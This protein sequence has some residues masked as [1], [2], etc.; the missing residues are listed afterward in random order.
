MNRHGDDGPA[1]VM[2]LSRRYCWMKLREIGAAMGG[3]DYA[4]VSDRLRR[5]DARIGSDKK[6]MALARTATENLNLETCPFWV[7]TI[8]HGA[9]SMERP[10]RV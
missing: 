5:L 9:T 8:S 6:L 7:T 4:A 2:W 10:E 1:L 3:K